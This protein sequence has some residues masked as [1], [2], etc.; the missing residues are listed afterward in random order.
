MLLIWVVRL[1]LLV[2]VRLWCLRSLVC[3]V[4][5]GFVFSYLGLRCLLIVALVFEIGVVFLGLLVKEVCLCL[6]FML[7]F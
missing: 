2:A 6:Y 3:S 5:I 4:L 7:W 1:R